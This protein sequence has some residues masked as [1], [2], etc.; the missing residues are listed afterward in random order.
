VLEVSGG[1]RSV[2]RSVCFLGRPTLT[3]RLIR[4]I[5]LCRIEARFKTHG[6]RVQIS[7][8]KT[9]NENYC[10]S[11]LHQGGISSGNNPNIAGGKLI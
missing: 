2:C 5:E 9:E 3:E 11:P 8:V 1:R 4:R 6:R 10:G 7:G